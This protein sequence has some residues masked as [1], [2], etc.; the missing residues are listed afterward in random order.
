[1]KRSII[2]FITI[3][4]FFIFATSCK[5]ESTTVDMGTFALHLHTNIDTN[6][7]DLGTAYHDASGR[8]ILLNVAQFFISNVK[9]KKTDG[10]FYSISGVTVL[11]TPDEEEY[12]IGK[13][14]AGNYSSVT[15]DVGV[16]SSDNHSDPNSFPDTSALHTTDPNAWYG[17]TANG[18]IFMNI[19]G[20]VDTSAGNNG[21]VDFPISYQIGTDANLKTVSM[22]D[23]AFTIPKD[24]TQLVHIICDYGA[25]LTGIDF[26]TENMTTTFTNPDVATKI[27]NNISSTVMFRYEM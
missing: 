24:E 19:Q 16:Q 12:I 18:Y 21:N 15:F 25:V 3:G 17:T 5:K 2:T 23:Q 10:T 9:L 26:K 1:M 13:A 22:P 8:Q 7:A 14:P 11:K 4:V 6:E 27:V 20:M